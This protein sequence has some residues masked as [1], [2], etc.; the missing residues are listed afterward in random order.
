[1]LT[2]QFHYRLN[3]YLDLWLTSPFSHVHR[4]EADMLDLVSKVTL[5]SFWEEALCS[6][7]SHDNLPCPLVACF[8]APLMWATKSK[9]AFLKYNYSAG[10]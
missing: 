6:V 3:K 4:A 2:C 1:M 10:F 9:Y 8:V 7:I 5:I